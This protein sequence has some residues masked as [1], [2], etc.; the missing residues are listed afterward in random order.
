MRTKSRLPAYGE[1]ISGLVPAVHPFDYDDVAFGVVGAQRHDLLVSVRVVPGAGPAAVGELD[2]DQV[3]R[4][5][6][7]Q[8]LD[9][10]AVHDEPAAERRQR[11]IDPLQVLHDRRPHGD[12][13]HMSNGVGRHDPPGSCPDG[14]VPLPPW[15]ALTALAI[16]SQ[17]KFPH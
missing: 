15:A 7:F 6:A 2:D 14:Y 5:T 1:Y 10:A 11:G 13:A 12:L 9:L 4:P 17:V 8:H 16:T 3:A